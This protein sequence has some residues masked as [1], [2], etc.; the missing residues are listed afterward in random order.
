V[1]GAAL[2]GPRFKSAG[3]H[4]HPLLGRRVGAAGRPPSPSIGFAQHPG[5]TERGGD[6][7]VSAVTCASARVRLSPSYFM[8]A[9]L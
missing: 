6:V 8:V 2:V 7:A 4:Q 5:R 9:F 3:R 1:W